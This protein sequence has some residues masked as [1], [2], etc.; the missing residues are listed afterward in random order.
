MVIAWIFFAA[1]GMLTARH[2]KVIDM[3]LFGKDIW[4]RIHQFC[5]T[6][7][8]VLTITAVVIIFVERGTAPLKIEAL[9]RNPH[10]LIGLL[11]AILAFIQPFMAFFRPHPGADNR[12]IFNMSHFTVGTTAMI[13]S[14][15]AII[16]ASY[17]EIAKVEE[18]PA[19]IVAIVFPVFYFCLHLVATL[20]I[21]FGTRWNRGK[22]I[23]ITLTVALFGCLALT[24]SLIAIILKGVKL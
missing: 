7:V 9:K 4:F 3:Q 24:T 19:K 5:M 1:L 12:W 15:T 22:F 14:M 6:T 16:L 17:L 10:G 23:A 11:A 13:L 18:Q 8:W 21:F 2:G 20:L